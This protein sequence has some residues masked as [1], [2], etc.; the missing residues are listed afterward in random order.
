MKNFFIIKKLFLLGLIFFLISPVFSADK[1]LI[2]SKLDFNLQKSVITGKVTAED[3]DALPGV[4]VY[5]KSLNLFTVTNLQGEFTLANV[6]AGQ[7]QLSLS[8]LGFE[9]LNKNINVIV[10]QNLNIGLLKLQTKFNKLGE[11]VITSSIEGQQKAYNQQKNADN[12]KNIV[13]ADLIGRFPDVNVAEALQR[14]SG[15]SIQRN[16]G[17]GSVVQIRGTPLNYTTIAVNGEQIPSTEE[18]GKR[19]ES[20]DLISADQLA[21]MEISKAV[22]PDMDGDAIGGAINLI[23]PTAKSNKMNLKGT[24]GSGYNNLYNAGISTFKLG[25]DQRFFNSKLGVLVGGSYYNTVNGEERIETIYGL[26]K[27]ATDALEINDFSM[28]P[29]QNT[30]KRTTL[31]TTIDYKFNSNSKIYFNAL[32][33]NLNDESLRN[34]FRIR[35]RAG[36]YTALDVASGNNV[37]VRK[38][39]NDRVIDK[40]TYTFNLGGKHLLNKINTVLDYEGFYTQSERILESKRHTFRKRD[41]TLNVD[42]SNPDF[43]I[44]SPLNTNFQ[45]NKTYTFTSYEE[46]KPIK[47]YGTSLVTKFNLTTPFKIGKHNGEIKGGGKYRNIQNSRRRQTNVFDVLDGVYDLSQVIGQTNISIFDNTYNLGF[48]PNFGAAQEYFTT[49][50]SNFVLNQQQTRGQ[51][52]SFYFNANEQVY[53]GYAQ[54]KLQINNL[55]ILA[56]L[57]YE[58]TL[59]K[60]DAFRVDRTPAGE[61]KSSTPTNGTNDY[62][63]LLPM[64]HLKYKLN[65]NENLRFAATK[66]YSRPNFDDL[67][68][69]QNVD[70]FNLVLSTGNP[71]LV[72]ASAV[73]LDLIY[74][75]FFKGAGVI[76]GGLFYKHISNFIFS[77]QSI[78]TTGQF[79]GFRETT[80]IN[81][82][83]AKVYGIELNFSKKLDFLPGPFAGLSTF[84]NYTYSK[85]SSSLASRNNVRFPGQADHI[86]NAAMAFDKKAFSARVSLNYNGAFVTN[87]ASD[88]RFD[89]YTDKRFQLDVNGSYKASKR[90]TIFS[91]FINLTNEK[92]IEYQ[93]KRANPLNIEA[94]GWS[95]RFGL[96]YKL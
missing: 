70:I 95:T 7:Y 43:P 8:Y 82:S 76:S 20:L 39:I 11:V 60:Y 79:A 5:I 72:P 85:S 69:S 53:A 47:N 24:L 19:S 61:W 63:F 90:I 28:R 31:T 80:P 83:L 86:W 84:L 23:T 38:D 46:D 67:V 40:K 21:S 52:D 81:G 44:F 18:A 94:Y 32:Y 1:T 27:F 42:R 12:I 25:Y 48:F 45:D 16:N 30:R 58:K 22:T 64:L 62:A 54:S 88:P 49:N 13:S 9:T 2:S 73:N 36:S 15:I 26:S 29:L 74:E 14:V 59:V 17:E 4:S 3:N 57:R 92:R 51:S 93:F 89:F 71:N 6:P 35:P 41:F 50:Q 56:G 75:G 96:N 55:T 34:R 10:G 68:P 77:Q 91:E 65:E 66:T 78:L 87:L 33:S 37:E